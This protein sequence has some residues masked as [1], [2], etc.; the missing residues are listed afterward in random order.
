[1][2]RRVSQG[3]H[4]VAQV[5]GGRHVDALA[6]EEEAVVGC[7]RHAQRCSLQLL[8]Q[9]ARDRVGRGGAANVGVE[10]E[11]GPREGTKRRSLLVAAR[12]RVGR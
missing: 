5:V 9:V 2:S 11:G 3:H 10:V 6:V 12:Q 1:V 7:P 8:Q 4:L